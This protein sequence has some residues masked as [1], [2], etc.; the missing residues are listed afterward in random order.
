MCYVPEMQKTGNTEKWV[1]IRNESFINSNK[2]KANT[3]E[4]ITILRSDTE[5]G[6]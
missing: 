1:V 5:L 6:S 4:G 2:L 3:E